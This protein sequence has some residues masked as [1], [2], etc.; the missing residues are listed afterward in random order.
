MHEHHLELVGWVG[1][2]TTLGSATSPCLAARLH[3]RCHVLADRGRPR[4]G[5][6]LT[7]AWP[8]LAAVL[9]P[10][11]AVALLA[12][13]LAGSGPLT[14]TGRCRTVLLLLLPLWHR[15][16]LL[17]LASSPRARGLAPCCL[18]PSPRLNGAVVVH[19]VLPYCLCACMFSG[20]VVS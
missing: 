11:L 13:C 4:P 19:A 17:L 18:A 7:V 12:A 1:A 9:L 2:V 6:S 14:A 16:V 10:H 5:R 8:L 15:A 3:A 20:Y